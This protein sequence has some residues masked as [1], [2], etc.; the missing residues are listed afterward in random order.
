MRFTVEECQ[1]NGPFAI[2]WLAAKGELIG[3][4]NLRWP[5]VACRNLHAADHRG[6]L[7]LEK[8][9]IQHNQRLAG[10]R[11]SHSAERSGV[12]ELAISND[13]KS[14]TP[15]VRLTKIYTLRRGC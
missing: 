9:A 10:R 13:S 4:H 2:G 15:S 1:S 12:S 8:I 5:T 7:L 14:G 6:C 11:S 3:G